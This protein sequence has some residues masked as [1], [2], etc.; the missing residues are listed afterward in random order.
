MT[1]CVRV[2]NGKRWSNGDDAHPHIQTAVRSAPSRLATESM[3]TAHLARA[4]RE[5]RTAGPRAVQTQKPTCHALATFA[6]S[7]HFFMFCANSFQGDLEPWFLKKSSH[8]PHNDSLASLG[9]S[10]F[11]IGRHQAMRV[12]R[13]SF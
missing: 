9:L 11:L 10:S 5:V 7:I 4:V 8:A 12:P 3:R 2:M 6:P 1:Q 13:V